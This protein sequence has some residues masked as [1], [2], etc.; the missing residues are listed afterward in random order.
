MSSKPLP[1]YSIRNDDKLLD[2][3]EKTAIHKSLSYPADPKNTST[4]GKYA[5]I[6][7]ALKLL[8]QSYTGP[9]VIPSTQKNMKKDKV[10]H[11]SFFS[12]VSSSDSNQ[13]QPESLY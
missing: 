7:S 10:L 3:S 2:Q 13:A 8:Y 11:P 9:N 12:D 1:P 6:S 5:L 4:P